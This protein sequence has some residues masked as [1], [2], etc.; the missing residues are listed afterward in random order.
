MYILMPAVRFNT[1][2]KLCNL[3]DILV[4]QVTYFSLH[5]TICTKTRK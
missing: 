4:D 5:L 3:E 1:F 2:V